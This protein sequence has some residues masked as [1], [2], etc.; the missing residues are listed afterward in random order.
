[1]TSTRVNIIPPLPGGSEACKR[2]SSCYRHRLLLGASESFARS[3]QCLAPRLLAPPNGSAPAGRRHRD[4]HLAL[5]R[6]LRRIFK[7]KQSGA[8]VRQDVHGDPTVHASVNC[9]ER[10]TLHPH[11]V[12]QASGTRATPLATAWKRF[13][14]PGLA[15]A[16]VT[17]SGSTKRQRDPRR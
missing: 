14:E 10:A 12:A 15:S 17:N 5:P 9:P 6:R 13:G 8:G 1:M 3:L 16:R 7:L 2:C 11:P 4:P